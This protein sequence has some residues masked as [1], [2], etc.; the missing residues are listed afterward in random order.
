MGLVIGIDT[1]GTFTD[2]V[3]FD[4]ATG[5]VDSLKTSST[6]ATPGQA[7]V[8]A[9]D[10]GGVAAAEIDTFTHGT[11]VGTNALIE[12]N[13]LPGRV[14]H[15][16]GLRGHALHPADQP[17][18]A[19]RPALD[20]A[21]AARREPSPLSRT[22]R[23]ARFRRGRGEGG[24]RGRG[25]GAR[26][27]DPRLRRRRGGAVPPLLLRQ[28]RPRGPRQGDPRR[29]A[30]GCAHLRLVRGGADLARVRAVVDHDRRCLSAAAGR[31]LRRQPRRRAPRRGHD[32]R[33][34]DDEVERRRDAL[35]RSGGGSDPDRDVGARGRDDRDRAHRTRARGDRTSSP[36]TWA[37][38]ARTSASSSAALS[39]TRP[40]TR[41]SGASRRRYR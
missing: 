31:P 29:R 37:E 7:I 2:M 10:E 11:T 28:H 16:E 33:V 40:N 17:Q 34:D 15:D 1:G 25:A 39:G 8:N 41:S 30:A 24:R 36:S 18:G 4:P 22:C 20:E 26:A 9:L 35:G 27:Q 3:I 14:R 12:R 6:P 13:G 19:L 32:G 5:E 21:G 23:A 38:R